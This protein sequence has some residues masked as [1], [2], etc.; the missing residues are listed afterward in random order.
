MNWVGG[1]L[2]PTVPTSQ[3]PWP[4]SLGTTLGEQLLC[5]FFL[6]QMLM[7]IL[8]SAMSCL[9]EED[10]SASPRCVGSFS[11][12]TKTKQLWYAGPGTGHWEHSKD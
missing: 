2:T 9:C 11:Q 3:I 10:R 1:T 12:A 5:C 4:H 8:A 6:L 7:D